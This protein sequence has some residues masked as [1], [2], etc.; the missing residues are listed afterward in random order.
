MCVLHNVAA[1]NVVNDGA[2]S[3]VRLETDLVDTGR[4][5]KHFQ[6]V[7]QVVEHDCKTKPNL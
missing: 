3:G 2:E 7:L 1:V 4:S 5:D 6:N